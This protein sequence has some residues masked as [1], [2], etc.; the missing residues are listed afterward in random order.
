[1][2]I[3]SILA[4]TAIAATTAAKAVAV[5]ETIATVGTVLVAVQPIADKIRD[6]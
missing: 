1:M 3:S 4:A 5:G 6:K 2:I